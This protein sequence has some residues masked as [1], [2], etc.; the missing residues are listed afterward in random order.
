MLGCG[1]RRLVCF[2][3]WCG[4]GEVFGWNWKKLPCKLL[5][6]EDGLGENGGMNVLAILVLTLLLKLMVD[7]LALV[8]C[9]G[10][11]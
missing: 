1:G 3:C 4:C 6:D 7:L 8:A 9:P 5:G 2:W 11:L 10:S